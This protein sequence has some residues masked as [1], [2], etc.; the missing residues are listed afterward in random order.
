MQALRQLNEKENLINQLN[1]IKNNL[2][3][4]NKYYRNDSLDLKNKPKLD[5]DKHDFLQ[6]IFKIHNML[7]LAAIKPPQINNCFF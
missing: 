3:L 1:I 5:I 2:S 4:N 6:I 7:S